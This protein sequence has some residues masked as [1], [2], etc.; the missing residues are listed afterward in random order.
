MS[1]LAEL[2]AELAECKD[3][4]E[5]CNTMLQMEP[6]DVDAKETKAMM[7]EQIADVRA[8][9]AA[10][11]AKQSAIVPPPPPAADDAPPPPP[12]KYDMSKHPKFRKQSPEAPPAPP[13]DDSHQQVIF[14]VK[15]VV[16]AKY[17]EDKQWYQATVVSRTGS[18]TDPVYTVTFKGYGNTETK[19]KHEIRPVHTENKKR[20]AD[21][22]PA[23]TAALP[24]SASPMPP[25]ASSG[26]AHVISAAPSV[27]HTLVQQTVKREPSKVS[28]GP[29]RMAPE[30]KKLKGNK[31]L[32]K[33]KASWNSWQQ[34]GPKKAALTAPKQ[35]DSMF[36]TPTNPNGRVGYVGAG[37]TLQKEQERSKWAYA[38]GAP[39]EEDDD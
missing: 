9:I 15:D 2:E 25:T 27:D 13:G 3:N 39:A 22:S 7:E 21:G 38:G 23:V 11:K 6:D 19:R 4:V 8:Q 34:S 35:K 20:K 28:D 26:G 36:R 5:T 37:K 12:Q 31:A 18:S 32:E 33:G 1:K 30:P 14:D 16:L 24:T 17:T 29:T 10:E